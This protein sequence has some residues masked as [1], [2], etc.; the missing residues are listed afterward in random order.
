LVT[1]VQEYLVMLPW[2]VAGWVM[3]VLYGFR[4]VGAENVPDQGPFILLLREYG[5]V[6]FLG[7]GLVSIQL[8]YAKYWHQREKI[9]AYMHEGLWALPY[10]PL[11]ARLA[12]WLQ[13]LAPTAAG[14]LTLSLLDGYR[15]LKQGGMVIMNPEGDM[16][17][18]GRPLPYGTAAAWLSL[19][20]GAPVLP[21]ICASGSYDIWPRWQVRP[22]LRGK[23]MLNI[24]KPFALSETPLDQIDDEVLQD[25]AARLHAELNRLYYGDGGVPEWAGPPLRDGAPLTQPA[26]AMLAAEADVPARPVAA[27]GQQ[28]RRGMAQLL[29]RC[30]VCHTNEGPMQERRWFRPP[31]VRCLACGTR[32]DVQRIVGKDFRLRI[33][34]GPQSLIGLDMPL[35]SW[36]EDI[37]ASLE[38]TAVMVP[39]LELEP[40]EE[41]YLAAEGVSLVPHK[42]SVL[43]DGWTEGEAPQAQP[44][45]SRDYAHWDSIGT[46]RLVLTNQRLVWQAPQGN[47]SFRWP[48]VNALHLWLL[49]T[50]IILYGTALYRLTVGRENGL[51]WHSYVGSVLREAARRDGRKVDIRPA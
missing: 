20:T 40:Q 22:S 5:V 48:A 42:P 11:V 10:F 3:R 12:P 37:K 47:L 26:R 46:G 45:G 27:R 24:G 8:L 41:P 34:K 43:S 9:Q 31:I 17:W 6:G 39:G 49:N 38:M 28:W 13:P 36:Y 18:D 16:P 1:D 32:W 35:S 25:G 30:P 19:H 21:M 15:K 4:T 33:T 2:Y 29:W 50:L 23:L 7:S 44:P 14:R 51:K